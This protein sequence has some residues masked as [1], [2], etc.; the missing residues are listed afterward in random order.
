MD[1][2]NGKAFSTLLQ[3]VGLGGLINECVI[4]VKKGEASITAVDLSNS[5]FIHCSE[6]I[7]DSAANVDFGLNNIPLI[8]SFVE[9]VETLDVKFSDKW[10]T[11]RRKGGTSLK[12]LS[13]DPAEV[14]TEVSESGSVAKMYGLRLN[15]V[16]LKPKAVENLL[17]MIGLVKSKSILL[18][19]K[20]GELTASSSA[21][22]SEQFRV[23]FGETKAK[24]CAV[25]VFAE[26]LS[27]LLQALTSL[28][29]MDAVQMSVADGKPVILDR[30]EG[31]FWALTPLA[32]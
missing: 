15:P 10:L 8:C 20:D 9:K 31:N 1:S 24:D 30:G 28:G 6:K 23:R 3:R 14:P 5:V 11:L 26:H 27:R 18:T 21:A 13:L 25:T 4:H 32:E 16:E 12:C 22:D 7:S 17:F 29:E 19:V 2:L